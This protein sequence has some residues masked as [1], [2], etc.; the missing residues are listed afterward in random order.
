MT[1]HAFPHSLLLDV[2]PTPLACLLVC[3]VQIMRCWLTAKRFGLVLIL[4]ITT[5]VQ[6][7]ASVTTSPVHGVTDRLH[8]AHKME[9][10]ACK[11]LVF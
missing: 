1:N 7:T 10:C 8:Q 11:N 4:S 5:C 3:K 2:Y 9:A 6:D